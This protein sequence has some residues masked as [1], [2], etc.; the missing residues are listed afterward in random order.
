MALMSWLRRLGEREDRPAPAQRVLTHRESSPEES[1]L[2][3]QLAHDPNDEAAFDAL[4]E[5]VRERA[6]EGTHVD[7]LTAAPDTRVAQ[8]HAVWALAEE[9][10]GKPV[11][12]LPLIVMARLSL[13]ADHEAAMR[14]LHL[15]CERETTGLALTHAVAMLRDADAPAEAITFGVAHWELASRDP[16]AASEIIHAALETGRIEEARRLL[17]SLASAPADLTRTVEA[18]EAQHA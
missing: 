9:L 8:D 14:R 16:E 15:A 13:A 6:D 3:D 4:V 5:I 11:A 18:A 10:A 2:R 1:E 7:P 12:W 17:D